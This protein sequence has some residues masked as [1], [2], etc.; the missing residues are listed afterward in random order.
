MLYCWRPFERKPI[1]QARSDHQNKALWDWFLKGVWMYTHGGLEAVAQEWDHSP[2]GQLLCVKNRS[3]V[4]ISFTL[5][6]DIV[7]KVNNLAVSS[8]ASYVL[9]PCHLQMAVPNF[10]ITGDQG[11]V[12]G[13]A[14]S[15]K[16]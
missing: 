3:N 5:F 11:K 1:A 4:Q 15:K 12:S 2:N 8:Y 7:S 14:L 10:L 16:K 9:L 6:K 13:L